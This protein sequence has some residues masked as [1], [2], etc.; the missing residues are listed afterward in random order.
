GLWP[1][2]ARPFNDVSWSSGENGVHVAGR[3][4]ILSARPFAALDSPVSLEICLR[5]DSS[6]RTSTIL[7]FSMPDGSQPFRLKQYRAAVLIQHELPGRH[8]WNELEIEIGDVLHRGR[9]VFITFT[10]ASRGSI[11]YVNGSAAI[12]APAFVVAS[13]QFGGQLVLG[14]S[15]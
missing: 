13:G 12:T 7:A 1:F 10:S 14:A 8:P 2:D 9:P 11:V 4:I 6:N 3:G 15:A 5:P